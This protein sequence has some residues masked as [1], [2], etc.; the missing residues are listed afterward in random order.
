MEAYTW[1]ANVSTFPELD[2]QKE[3]GPSCVPFRALAHTCGVYNCADGWFCLFFFFYS[4]G[5]TLSIARG[6]SMVRML[7]GLPMR[8]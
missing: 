6:R 8:R 5:I 7:S 2:K 4:L 1:F 3:V